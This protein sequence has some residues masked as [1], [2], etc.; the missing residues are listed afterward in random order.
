MFTGDFMRVTVIGTIE[1]ASNPVI[2]TW[3][4]R[5]V[6]AS[7]ANALQNVGEYIAESFYARY[8]EPL[9]PQISSYYSLNEI[10]LRVYGDAEEGYDWVNLPY[11]G[12]ASGA[13][14]PPFVTYSVELQRANFTMR[15]GRKA[16]PGVPTSVVVENGQ[17]SG[18]VELAFAT[19]FTAWET[20]PW[21]AEA[22]EAD[23]E[24]EHIIVRKPA[25]P[26]AIPTTFSRI[27][28]Y[29]LEKFGT[30]NS[31]KQ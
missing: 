26:N 24:F 15:N 19:V 28:G 3:D 14:C 30:Q 4:Y 11:V 7:D 12:G 20:T 29:A 16:Y 9:M 13:M 2:N 25:T 23:F 6:L 18:A 22:G 17:L 27:T 31:R 1:G 21:L 5:C 8:Y 10:Q